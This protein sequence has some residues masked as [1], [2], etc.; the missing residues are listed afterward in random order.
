[1]A[2]SIEL[3]ERIEGRSVSLRALHA[4]DVPAYMAAFDADPELGVAMGREQDPTAAEL[5]ERPAKAAAAAAEGQWA[6]L[7]IAD[8]EDRLLGTVTLHSPDWRHEHIE[9]GFWLT[10]EARG[11]GAATEATE[12]IV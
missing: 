11:R 4:D 6:E 3:P 9:V 12:L 2:R 5:R 7:A 1:M 10:P 8:G